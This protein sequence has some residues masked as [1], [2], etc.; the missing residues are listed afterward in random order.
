MLQWLFL[1]LSAT[2]EM[3]SFLRAE[4]F[5]FSLVVPDFITQLRSGHDFH[6]WEARVEEAVVVFRGDL[7]ASDLLSPPPAPF[8][9]RPSGLSTQG[10]MPEW[11]QG[12][13]LPSSCIC[14]PSS[15]PSHGDSD[16]ATGATVSGMARWSGVRMAH[17]AC[18]RASQGKEPLGTGPQPLHLSCTPHSL[19]CRGVSSLI[20]GFHG[21]SQ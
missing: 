10:A 5:A 11:L 19:L 20:S 12:I 2:M 4:S 17:G 21:F 16:G 1:I 6:V 13:P 9:R 3:G 18:H 7:G 14:H 8:S 15:P